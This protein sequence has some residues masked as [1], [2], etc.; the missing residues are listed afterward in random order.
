MRSRPHCRPPLLSLPQRSPRG[1]H[2]LCLSDSACAIAG[3]VAPRQRT[4][5]GAAASSAGG[6]VASSAGGLTGVGGVQG[7][8]SVLASPFEVKAALVHPGVVSVARLRPRLPLHFASCT[9]EGLVLFWDFSKHPSFPQ[10]ASATPSLSS[11][12]S[13]GGSLVGAAVNPASSSSAWGVAANSVARPQ[14]LMAEHTAPVEGLSWSAA[15]NALLASADGAGLCCLWDLR[16]AS[17]GSGGGRDEGKKN[18]AAAAATTRPG[19][20]SRSPDGV[21]IAEKTPVCFSPSCRVQLGHALNDV[22]QHPSKAPLA[23]AAS[24][25]G[26]IFVIDWRTGKACAQTAANTASAGHGGGAVNLPAA[27]VNSTSWSLQE[28]NVFASGSA[29]GGVCLFDLR[30]LQRP[31]LRLENTKREAAAAA[32][33]NAVRFHP[34]FACFLAAAAEDSTVAV[35]DLSASATSSPPPSPLFVHGGHSAAVT[36]FCWRTQHNQPNNGT[37]GG[38]CGGGLHHLR[39]SLMGASVAFDNKVQLWQGAEDVFG[40]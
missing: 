19:P 30:S 9:P 14:L 3:F 11:S 21:L 28:P 8:S 33:V 25:E 22:Q 4:A 5:R 15:E 12:N 34:D 26:A 17:E 29:D 1:G 40:E 39:Q 23:A 24:E 10:Q 7:G 27:A 36:D 16:G 31:L 2:S 13:G 6:V 20:G 35:W 18:S 32:G 37:P 38:G